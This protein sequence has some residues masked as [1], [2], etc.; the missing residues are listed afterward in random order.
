MHQLEAYLEND[1]LWIV[2]KKNYTA[3]ETREY[4]NTPLPNEIFISH[5]M[6]QRHPTAIM[7]IERD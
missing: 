5:D 3:Y 2:D 4:N 6:H 7:D 1:T